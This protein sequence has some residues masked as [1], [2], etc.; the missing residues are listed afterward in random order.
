MGRIN[1]ATLHI[2][3]EADLSLVNLKYQALQKRVRLSKSKIASWIFIHCSKQDEFK[4]AFF[5]W[6]EEQSILHK[7]GQ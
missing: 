7:K 3:A 4:E 2:S 5:K 6:V 1:S